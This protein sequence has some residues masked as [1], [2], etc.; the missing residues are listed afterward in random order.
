MNETMMRAKVHQA[1]DS[2]CAHLKEDYW[3]AQRVIA[4]AKDEEGR[5]QPA[6]RPQ[7]RSKLSVA[8][9][10]V[11]VLMLMS[12]TAVAAVVLSW[13]E[14]VEQEIVPIAQQND[15]EETV[16]PEFSNEELRQVLRIAEENGV[17]IPQGLV[18]IAEA[19]Y[20]D[21][22]EETLRALASA[23]F[24]Y[25]YKYWT[26]EQRYWYGEVEV[27]IGSAEENP[28]HLPGEG[29]I[30]FDEAMAIVAGIAQADGN[31]LY[32]AERWRSS[33][34]YAC[35]RNE[36]GELSSSPIW[37]M[38]FE[39]TS[40]RYDYYFF[41]LSPQ[42]EVLTSERVAAPGESTQ[43]GREIVNQYERVY[44]PDYEWDVETWV[45]L[46]NDLEGKRAG[47]WDIWIYQHAGYRLPP[48]G[49]ITR[50]QAEAI[51]VQAVNMEITEV[52]SA[53]CCSDGDT[54]IW[55]IET[56]SRKPENIRSAGYDAIWQFEIDCMTGEI[57]DMQEGGYGADALPVMLR[58]IPKRIYDE[59]LNEENG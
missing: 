5:A 33:F 6:E 22:E 19:G 56:R 54:P 40:I 13:Q 36:E 44:G 25:S 35:H 2:H 45:A 24:G 34:Q 37:E 16:E 14:V 32:D 18:D 51:A 29:E 49:G 41:T 21:W 39:P 23:S 43:S 52:F 58:Y 8:L 9:V 17:T 53:V 50:E 3:L 20:G 46:S 59:L 15:A 31:D 55:K 47:A 12:V 26:I 1:V 4:M 28:H 30:S 38:W 7:R 27:A 11:L 42:G 10:I 48:A 57:R